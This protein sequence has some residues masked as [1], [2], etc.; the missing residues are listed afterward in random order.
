[1]GAENR[2]KAIIWL[3]LSLLVF[4]LSAEEKTERVP[5]AEIEAWV[6]EGSSAAKVTQA[7]PATKTETVAKAKPAVEP[8]T[9][10]AEKPDVPTALKVNRKEDPKAWQYRFRQISEMIRNRSIA[11]SKSGYRDKEMF[12]V[13][14]VA[15]N[16]TAAIECLKRM[17]AKRRLYDDEFKT[18]WVAG[19]YWK[20]FLLSGIK[21]SPGHL[22]KFFDEWV[23][24]EDVRLAEMVGVQ[25]TSTIEKARKK[26]LADKRY[27]EECKDIANRIKQAEEA[28]SS[29][30]KAL[31]EMCER[32]YPGHPHV[33]VVNLRFLY[34]L[35]EWYPEFPEVKNGTVQ[36]RIALAFAVSTLNMH[37]L[38]GEEFEHLLEHWPEAAYCRDGNAHY[39]AGHRWSDHGDALRDMRKRE[40]ARKAWKKALDHF[41]A[42]RKKHPK[43]WACQANATT[44]RVAVLGYIGEL[45]SEDRLGK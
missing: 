36:T 18:G 1:V 31:W 2:S 17:Y 16:Y 40:E 15:E 35:R 11:A 41:N 24:G 7:T 22:E 34:K 8:N 33:P 27:F 29:D 38:S 21:P 32:F 4:S 12:R 42:L 39:Y 6:R 45:K 9:G 10:K 23:K 14:Y 30:P 25:S 5:W 3:G 43:H 20:T 13:F 19:C 26:F 44:G 37:G 28:G